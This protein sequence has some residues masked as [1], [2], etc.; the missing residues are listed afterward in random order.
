MAFPEV[1][2]EVV[3]LTAGAAVPAVVDSMLLSL[4]ND[5]F[6]TAYQ[7][8]LKVR[9][10]SR[11]NYDSLPRILMFTYSHLSPPLSLPL[12]LP[13]AST[14]KSTTSFGYAVCDVVTE[15]S[16]RVARIDLPD[17]VM[18]YLMD[19]LSGIEH[20]LSQGVSEKVQVGALVG[21][22]VAARSMMKP[23]PAK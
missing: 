17:P 6:A 16:S 9:T 4:L 12:F 19:R 22:F 23:G 10:P 2:E 5:D 7:S 11:L 15:L 3:Y 20:R 21:A 1:T 8:I 14:V 18:A 13:I